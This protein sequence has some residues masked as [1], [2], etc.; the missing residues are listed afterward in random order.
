MNTVDV[1]DSAVPPEFGR[2]E[3][4]ILGE[5]ELRT[6]IAPRQRRN[7][8]VFHDWNPSDAYAEHFNHVEYYVYDGFAEYVAAKAAASE[9]DR[10]DIFTRRMAK[11]KSNFFW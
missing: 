10:T 1:I 7:N 8:Y 2:L 9:N 6:S 3:H 5:P 4:G 11:F